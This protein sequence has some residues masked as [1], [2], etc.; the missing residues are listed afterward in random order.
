M[1]AN[2][3]LTSFTSETQRRIEEKGFHAHWFALSDNLMHKS[4]FGS[5]ICE[6]ESYES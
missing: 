1:N 5:M 3:P 2:K 4:S 6:Y